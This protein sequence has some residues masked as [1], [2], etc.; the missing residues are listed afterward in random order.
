[1]RSLVVHICYLLSQLLCCL[2]ATGLRWDVNSDEGEWGELSQW[3]KHWMRSVFRWGWHDCYNAAMS[4]HHLH[5]SRFNSVCFPPRAQDNGPLGEAGIL[6]A[7]VCCPGCIRIWVF[8]VK[9][10]QL[11]R[12]SAKKQMFASCMEGSTVRKPPL[13]R[14]D[15]CPCV[16]PT[17]TCPANSLNSSCAS[18][19]NLSENNFELVKTDQRPRLPSGA[20]CYTIKLRATVRFYS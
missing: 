6:A 20:P 19:Q 11:V 12:L 4:A 2:T 10:Q 16:L 3:T 14:L 18:N 8:G 5:R 9:P 15:V 1:M 17:S 13:P 7:V